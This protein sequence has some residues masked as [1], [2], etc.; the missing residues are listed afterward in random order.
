MRHVASFS[1]NIQYNSRY[2]AYQQ[3]I[4]QLGA[5]TD[6]YNGRVNI[7]QEPSPDVWFKLMERTN[8]RNKATSYVNA[9]NGVWEESVL[10]NAYFSAENIQIIQNAIRAGVYEKSGKKFIV[11][12]PKPDTLK[13]IMRNIFMQYAE[14]SQTKPIREQIKTLNDLVLGYAI[15]QVYSEAVG[16]NR[17]CEDQSTLVQPLDMPLRPDRTYKQLETKPWV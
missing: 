16:Y 7:I 3:T 13:I 9:L 2:M 15:P 12:A 6:K 17:Y 4:L 14:Y 5:T 8:N 1:D 10:S 11:A